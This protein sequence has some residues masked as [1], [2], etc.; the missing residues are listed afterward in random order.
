MLLAVRSIAL[1]FAANATAVLLVMLPVPVVVMA[2]P[3]L[4][5]TAPVIATSPALV[6]MD[7][8]PPTLLAPSAVAPPVVKGAFAI[9]ASPVVV[10]TVN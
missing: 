3:P 7:R 6:L 10:L 2:R 8:A 4:P 9:N 5:V 1:L